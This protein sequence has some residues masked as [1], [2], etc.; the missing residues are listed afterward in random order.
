MRTLFSAI[1]G[2]A[3][4]IAAPAYACSVV[5]GYRVPSS[6][7]LAERSDTILVGTVEGEVRSQE[8]E[9]PAS[10]GIRIRPTL[11]LKGPTLPAEVEIDGYLKGPRMRAPARSDPRELRTANPDSFSGACVRYLF[12]RGMKLVLFFDREDGKLRFARRPFARVAEDVRSDKALWVT[13][14]RLYVEV[15]ALPEAER[16]AALI[17]RRDALRARRGDKDAMLLADDIDVE[18]ERRRG[19]GSN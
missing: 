6:L 10:A 4:L 11:L 2:M 16:E 19:N 3:I 7:E 12:A 13:A 5:P 17:A 14:V 9:P 8:G 15:A 1:A 18:L